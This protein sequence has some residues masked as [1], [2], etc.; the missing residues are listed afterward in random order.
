LEVAGTELGP[1]EAPKTDGASVLVLVAPP[2][3]E[4]LPLPPEFGVVVGVLLEDSVPVTSDVAKAGVEE[5][6]T[7]RAYIS[8]IHFF[9]LL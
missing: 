7:A 4:L 9:R 2:P 6:S 8:Y 3:P 5:T 1:V